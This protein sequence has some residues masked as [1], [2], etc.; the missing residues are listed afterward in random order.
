MSLAGADVV[1][2]E[3]AIVTDRLGEAL[4]AVVGLAAEPAAPGFLAH[5]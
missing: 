5:G 3:T 2:I 4:D 1:T